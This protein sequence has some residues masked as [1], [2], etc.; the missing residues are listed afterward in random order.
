MPTTKKTTA[1]TE[2]T[3][4]ETTAE[5]ENSVVDVKPVAVNPFEDKVEMTLIPP[6]L[7]KEGATEYISCNDYVATAKY[8]EP[9][10]VP[11][12]IQAGMENQKMALDEL[13]KKLEKATKK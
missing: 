2:N 9:I 5:T 1:Q 8:N 4:T 7:D 3:K 11:R 10:K 12:F 13:R 6:T